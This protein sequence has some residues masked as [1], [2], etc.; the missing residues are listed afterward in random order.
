MTSSLDYITSTFLKLSAKGSG[1]RVALQT[2][3]LHYGTTTSHSLVLSC[4][5]HQWGNP[6]N[7]LQLVYLVPFIS[8]RCVVGHGDHRLGQGQRG[9]WKKRR[10]DGPASNRDQN[11][12]LTKYANHVDGIFREHPSCKPVQ[13]LRIDCLDIVCAAGYACAHIRLPGI[14]ESVKHITVTVPPQNHSIDISEYI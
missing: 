13:L 1:A 11:P 9:W 8:Q 10:R 2:C 6:I 7:Q 14:A 4:R 3:R 12:R 5:C